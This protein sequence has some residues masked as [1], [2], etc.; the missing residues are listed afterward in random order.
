MLKII[1]LLFSGEMWVIY[2][3]NKE[4]FNQYKYLKQLKWIKFKC[5]KTAYM[6]YNDSLFISLNPKNLNM[7]IYIF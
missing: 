2:Q 6:K 3:Q 7:R 4:Y 5:K 1:H